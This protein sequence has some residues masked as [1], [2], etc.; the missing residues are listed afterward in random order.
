MVETHD[1]TL[2]YLE[3]FAMDHDEELMQF[4]EQNKVQNMVKKTGR[5]MNA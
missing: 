5:D 1:A 4:A 3:L 2:V